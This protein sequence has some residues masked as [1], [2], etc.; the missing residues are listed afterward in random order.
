MEEL[1]KVLLEASPL[2]L[3]L[4]VAVVLGLILY[5][6]ALAY[7]TVKMPVVRA[8]TRINGA[9]N[10]G[11]LRRIH[12]GVESLVQQHDRR[13]ADGSKTWDCA[14]DTLR[15]V[16]EELAESKREQALA[17]DKLASAVSAIDRTLQR[18]DERM[19]ASEDRAAAR[20]RETLD[21]IANTARKPA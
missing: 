7:I 9:T 10:D 1:L 19:T 12:D 8:A 20:H 14:A 5:R 13:R 3:A 21:A 2:A 11:V 17:T 4:V 15:P 6:V 16:I 18:M